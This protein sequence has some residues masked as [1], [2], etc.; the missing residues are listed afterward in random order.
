MSI[1][2]ESKLKQCEHCNSNVREDHYNRYLKKMH[3]EIIEKNKK[4]D[5]IKVNTADKS[6]VH[7]R[8]KHICDRCGE[9][10][11]RPWIY[12]NYTG[13]DS[14]DGKLYLCSDCNK[15]VRKKSKVKP[16]P[17]DFKNIKRIRQ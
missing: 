16:D 12:Y 10:A 5:S 1:E 4:K 11:N 15:I 9:E 6:N 7:G 14:M 17:L 2:N 8:I 3:P 13:F